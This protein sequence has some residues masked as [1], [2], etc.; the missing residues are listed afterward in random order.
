MDE[1]A[2]QRLLL[3]H[4]DADYARDLD[5]DQM[6]ALARDPAIVFDRAPQSLLT[7]LALNQRNPFLR[8]PR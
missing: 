2:T 1:P 4:G 5:K 8:R 7:Y 6:A 3:E